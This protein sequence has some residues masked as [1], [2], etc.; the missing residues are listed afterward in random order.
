MT[1]PNVTGAKRKKCDWCGN[2]LLKMRNG[3]LM[4]FPLTARTNNDICDAC[5]KAHV[6][7]KTP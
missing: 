7:A 1:D 4:A 5:W 2:D 6:A 3:R